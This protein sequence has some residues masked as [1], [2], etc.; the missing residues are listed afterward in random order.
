VDLEQSSHDVRKAL[1]ELAAGAS[2]SRVTLYTATRGTE[3]RQEF[4]QA[5]STQGETPAES[6]RILAESTGGSSVVSLEGI[7]S[8]TERLDADL[9]GGYSLAWPSPHPADG[10]WHSLEVRARRPG[11]RVRS[12]AGY[13]ARTADQRTQERAAAALLLGI[14]ENPLDL[15]VD[16]GAGQRERDGSYTV[17]VT[18]KIPLA[19]LT[20]LPKGSEHQ[21][22]LSIFVIT[23]AADGGLSSGSKM[24]APIRIANANMVE[25]MGQTGV[26]QASLRVRPGTYR[27][28]VAARDDVA[29]VE[30][31]TSVDLE[32]REEGKKSKRGKDAG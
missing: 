3:A 17:P 16:L 11:A 1:R 23:Q 29:A 5:G 14:S 13:R 9:R 21:G 25:A 24:E 15:S 32:V 26:Y 30:S 28:A 20:L 12:A 2:A 10:A 6:L 7:E 18:L 19:R 27:V 22:H 31:A 8:L 4:H